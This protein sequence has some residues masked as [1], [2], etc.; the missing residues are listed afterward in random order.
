MQ[1]CIYQHASLLQ[2]KVT[3]WERSISCHFSATKDCVIYNSLVNKI[4]FFKVAL[5]KKYILSNT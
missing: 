1:N 5:F 4:N 2:E 3:Y